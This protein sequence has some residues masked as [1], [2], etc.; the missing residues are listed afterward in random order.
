MYKLASDVII[1][2][3]VVFI[4]NGATFKG[5]WNMY[6]VL[7]EVFLCF[8]LIFRFYIH[9]W[10]LFDA[11]HVII[12]FV[13]SAYYL[14]YIIYFLQQVSKGRIVFGMGRQICSKIYQFPRNRRSVLQSDISFTIKIRCHKA[15][16]YFPLSNYKKQMFKPNRSCQ[17]AWDEIGSMCK[18][19]LSV[20]RT[21]SNSV[22]QTLP[23]YLK[24]LFT[25]WK[26]T[27]NSYDVENLFNWLV[28]GF[29]NVLFHK[30]LFYFG[31]RVV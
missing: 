9:F 10:W 20:N 12:V 24:F 27:R 14:L 30:V 29:G 5:I 15:K 1:C 19:Q 4:E 25:V 8:M 17:K 31:L 26:F 13:I 6:L 11:C 7:N 21:E 28:L 18:S 23:N 22:Y 16:V 3:Y 2:V